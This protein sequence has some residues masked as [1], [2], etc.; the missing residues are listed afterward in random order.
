[1][2]DLNWYWFK[3]RM[4]PLAGVLLFFGILALIYLALIH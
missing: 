4:L 2:Q 1:L 3:R